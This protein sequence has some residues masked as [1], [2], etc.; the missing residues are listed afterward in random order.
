MRK[1]GN[2]SR[3]KIGVGMSALEQE[4]ERERERKRNEGDR[5]ENGYYRFRCFTD[6]WRLL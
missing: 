1:C 2:E 3:R 5:G 6:L 4:Q